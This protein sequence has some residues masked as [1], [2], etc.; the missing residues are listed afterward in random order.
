MSATATSSTS[1]PTAS[2]DPSTETEMQ[3]GIPPTCDKFATAV[4][5]DTCV[6]FAKAHGIKPAQ[7]YE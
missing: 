5:G 7:L 2:A 1:C 3:A 6:D 4:A